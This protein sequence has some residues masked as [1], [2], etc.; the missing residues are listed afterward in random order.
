[1]LKA[2]ADEQGQSCAE[3]E[4]AKQHLT[5]TTAYGKCSMNETVQKVL[6]QTLLI[7]KLYEF[8]H[9]V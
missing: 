3:P 6:L 1:M 4:T 5:T 2:G 8:A 9:E 7:D